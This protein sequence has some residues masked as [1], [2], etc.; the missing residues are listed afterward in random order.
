MARIFISYAWRDGEAVARWLYDRFNRAEGWSAWMDLDLHADTIFSYE[1]QRRINEADYVVVVVSPDVNR[2]DTPSFVQRELGYATQPQINKPVFAVRA[3]DCAIPLIIWGVTFVDFLAPD[4]YE[5]RFA[6]LLAKIEAGP[7]KRRES[8]RERELDYLREL[9]RN[10]ALSRAAKFYLELPAEARQPIK[11]DTPLVEDAE[12]ATFLAEMA[13]AVYTD[14][15]HAPDDDTTKQKVETFAE[16]S[17]ALAQ[18]DRVAIIGDP[19]SGKTTTLRRFAYMLGEQAAQD[20]NAPLPLYVPLGGYDGG[21]FERY[22]EGFFGGLKLREYLPKRAVLLLDG[23][24][25]TA[26][27]YVATIQNWLK[28]NPAVRVMLTCRKLDYVERKLDL[29]RVDVLPLDAVRIRQLML[30]YRLS[31]RAADKLFN[32]L[33]GKADLIY[34]VLRKTQRETDQY[35]GL[36]GLMRNPFLLTITIAIFARSGDVPRNRAQL[37]EGFIQQMFKER[38]EPASRKRPPWID[39][40]VQRNALAKLAHQMQQ[41]RTLVDTGWARDVI[42]KAAPEFDADHLLYLAASA[43]LIEIGKEV[44]FSH[45]LLQEY[46]AAW[47]MGE[48][49]RRGVPAARYWSDAEWWKPSGWEE[50]AIFLAGMG[51]DATDVVKWLTPVNPIL[52][53]RCVQESGGQCSGE[54]LQGL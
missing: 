1:L 27:E 46:F 2:Q 12:A 49:M 53:Y 33:S 51:D 5:T 17:A 35:P 25:E 40:S 4:T 14:K 11:P 37:F 13:M 28:Q 10:E 18:F 29:Q 23:L 44:R 34:D 26:F 20:E 15:R 31:A 47:E 3:E 41:T 48:D 38:G 45:Q 19:G 6:D 21:D 42:A 8:P 39:E 22:M 30:A 43:G 50:T 36:L 9:A 7:V 32:R 24:N 54:A 16:L 52:A